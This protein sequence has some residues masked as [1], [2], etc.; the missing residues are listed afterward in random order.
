MR[1]RVLEDEYGA[2]VAL[3]ILS[4]LGVMNSISE[5]LSAKV[6]RLFLLFVKVDVAANERLRYLRRNVPAP[7]LKD[8]ALNSFE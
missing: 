3:R 7:A 8:V 2:T 4:L 1:A 6:R 5:K